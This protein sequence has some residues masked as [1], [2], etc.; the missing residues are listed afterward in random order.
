MA[1]DLAAASDQPVGLAAVVAELERRAEAQHVPSAQGVTV[2]TLHSAKGLEW[3]AVALFGIQEGS[4]PFVLATRPEEVAEERRLLYV[5]LTRA[6]EHL[7]ISWSRSR[8][9]GQATRKPS[10]F[11]D[12]VLPPALRAA[13]AASTMPRTRKK[14]TV[15]SA[16]CRSCGHA[17]Q[18]AA[19]RKLGRHTD[20]PATYDERTLSLLKEWRKQ[21][22]AEEKVPA[23]CVFTDATLMAIAEAKPGSEQALIKI[24]GLGPAKLTKYGEQVLAILAAS[25]TS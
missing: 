16:H 7:H 9:G 18:D 6:R 5:G 17:L 21:E 15:L 11:L 1:E 8:G 2:S 22:A 12:P 10:R 25:D 20:C 14:G 3:D 24:P 23:F 19:E 13:G 4:L